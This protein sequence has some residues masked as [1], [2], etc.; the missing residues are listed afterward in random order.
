MTSQIA[1]CCF[2][3]LSLVIQAS[4]SCFLQEGGAGEDASASQCCLWSQWHCAKLNTKG[5]KLQIFNPS[6]LSPK[7]PANAGGS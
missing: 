6:E 3:A 4:P 7:L 1:L 2:E 5:G